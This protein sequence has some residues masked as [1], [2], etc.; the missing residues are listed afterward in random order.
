V[1][2][3]R[4]PEKY[5]NTTSSDAGLYV[6]PNLTPGHYKLTATASGFAPST[7]NGIVLQIGDAKHAD[8]LLN[9]PSATSTVT[10]EADGASVNTTTTEIGSV[11]NNQQAVELPLNGRDATM[12]VYLQAGT[13]PID[14]QSTMTANGGGGPGAQQQVGVVDGLPPS[15]SE[16]KV[17]GILASNPG[18]D[19]SPAHPSMPVPQEAV[20]EYRISTAGYSAGE[21]HGSGAQVN[22]L[23]KSGSNNF[24][25]S[26]FAFNRNTIYNAN[27]FFDKRQGASRPVL[28]RNQFGGSLGGPIRRGK[29]FIFGTAE[30]QRQIAQSIENRIVYTPSVAQW[31]LPLQQAWNKLVHTRRWKWDSCR[32]S[33]YDRHDQPDDSGS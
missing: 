21:G 24:H 22:V 33:F 9:I 1:Q 14:A 20:G 15:T 31:D 11:V 19:Y 2:F 32:Q 3:N 8:V 12:L 27:D 29:T 26:V 6:F 5:S 4:K 7:V 16:I 23:V 13:N 18:Y 28:M 25:G 17:E 30:W 10:V